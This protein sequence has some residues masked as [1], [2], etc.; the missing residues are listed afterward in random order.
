MKTAPTAA[1]LRNNTTASTELL[2]SAATTSPFPTEELLSAI[3]GLAD[4]LFQCPPSDPL[5]V[6]VQV[7]S[8]TQSY[9][10][11][12]FGMALRVPQDVFGIIEF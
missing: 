4:P 3:T 11:H 7:L 1:V 5:N 9:Q 6:S 2:T 12:I 8:F 10:C